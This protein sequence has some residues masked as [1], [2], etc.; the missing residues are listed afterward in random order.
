MCDLKT[1]QWDAELVG[2]AG[3][4]MHMLPQIVDSFSPVGI[5]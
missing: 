1:G 3:L 2:L 5:I 4:K